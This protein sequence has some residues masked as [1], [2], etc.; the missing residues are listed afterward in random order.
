MSSWQVKALFGAVGWKNCVHAVNCVVVESVAGTNGNPALQ[1]G[2]EQA[3]VTVPAPGDEVETAQDSEQLLPVGKTPGCEEVQVRG[4]L[5][6]ITAP[7]VL[8]RELFPITS[9]RVAITVCGVP[10]AV[11]KVV[12]PDPAVPTS[13]LMFWMGQVEKKSRI[14]ELAPCAFAY[15][16]C[17]NEVLV[18]P[19]AVA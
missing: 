5:P 17:W 19:L 16:G 14:G 3:A 11:T 9:V 4:T 12:C 15:C 8:G 6:R 7:L 18:T 13:R 1:V 2:G 10:L